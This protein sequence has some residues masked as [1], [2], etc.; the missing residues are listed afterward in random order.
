[1]RVGA[2]ANQRLTPVAD[3][4]AH[5]RN[6]KTSNRTWETRPSG[7]IGGLGKRGHGGI[8][9]PPRNRKGGPGNPLP[10][11]R[12]SEFYPNHNCRIRSLPT[13]SSAGRKQ[14]TWSYSR[15]IG[16]V[17]SNG[18]VRSCLPRMVHQLGATF[19]PS[20]TLQIAILSRIGWSP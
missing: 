9:I 3:G 8:V 20:R 18:V 13:K 4:K 5:Q 7:M 14:S 1:M 17:A 11:V 12:A 2:Y 19:E 10:T 6:A 15:H 16:Q